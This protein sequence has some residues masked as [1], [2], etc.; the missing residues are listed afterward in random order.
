[1]IACA[2]LIV[3]RNIICYG[4][5]D[6]AH[7]LIF[8]YVLHQKSKVICR[9]VVFFIVPA[10]HGC[11]MGIDHAKLGSF[12]VHH[13]NELIDCIGFLDSI[14]VNLCNRLNS[15]FLCS[16]VAGAHH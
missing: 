15:K 4:R 7:Q 9:G 6:F 8:Q 13:L 14:A 11:E 12:I 5:D 2:M 1:M 16:I 10:V 3:R